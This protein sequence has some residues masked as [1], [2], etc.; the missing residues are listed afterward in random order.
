MLD[1]KNIQ[2]TANKAAVKNLCKFFGIAILIGGVV[3]SEILFLG[4]VSSLFPS[5]PM[6]IGAMLGAVTTGVSILVLVL[7]KSSW[8]R[9]GSQL[10]IGWIFTGVEVMILILNDILAFQI[11]QGGQLDQYMASWRLFCVAAPVVSVVGWILC[12]YFDPQRAIDHRRMEMDDRVAR[13]QID[14][15]SRMHVQGMKLR[16]K[17]ADMAMAKFEEKV[18]TKLEHQLDLAAAKL[19]ANVASQLTGEHVSHQ[20]LLGS[21]TSKQL[22]SPKVVESNPPTLMQAASKDQVIDPGKVKPAVDSESKKLDKPKSFGQ[23]LG[24]VHAAFHG[25]IDRRIDGRDESR[26]NPVEQPPHSETTTVFVPAPITEEKP[27]HDPRTRRLGG[28]EEFEAQ[29]DNENPS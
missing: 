26:E 15:E 22:S 28:N 24:D 4:I 3:Y 14:Y 5:G 21:G 19:A 20:D 16:I 23:M 17:A 11:H 8:F 13:A 18:E 6:A 29:E 27:G 1:D 2:P 12:F 9:P 7:A 25:A 10:A